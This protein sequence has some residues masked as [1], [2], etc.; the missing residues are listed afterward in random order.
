VWSGDIMPPD[1]VKLLMR[2]EKAAA[3]K[4]DNAGQK[5]ERGQGGKGVGE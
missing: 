2:S 3:D 1:G 4:V 5:N